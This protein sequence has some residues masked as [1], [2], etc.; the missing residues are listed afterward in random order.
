MVKDKRYGAVQSLIAD[1]RIDRFGDI[2]LYVPRT[3]VATDLRLN[4]RTLIGKIN[5][6]NRFTVQD[7]IR[8]AEF[9]EVPYIRIFELIIADL[10]VK[11][12]SQ[13]PGT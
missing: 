9:I 8:L 1:K 2:F 3:V 4:Y 10:P 6:P 12:K 11:R 7:I 13:R 5:S